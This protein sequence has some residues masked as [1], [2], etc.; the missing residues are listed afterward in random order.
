MR[1]LRVYVAGPLSNPDVL[2]Y[3]Q[4][5]R[6][7]VELGAA[8]FRAGLA[9]FIPA[10]DG[11]MAAMCPDA[12]VSELYSYSL[13]WLEAADAVLLCPGWQNSKGSLAEIERARALSIPV[14]ESLAELL[15]WGKNGTRCD[16]ARLRVEGGT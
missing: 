2:G 11:P 7:A 8:A 9:P 10:L 15:A 16:D 4:N 3:L 13:A 12:K 1:R 6:R 14:F 5:V